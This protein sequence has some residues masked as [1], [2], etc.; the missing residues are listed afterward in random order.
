MLVSSLTPD[1]VQ[2]PESPVPM[3]GSKTNTIQDACLL[4]EQETS[5]QVNSTFELDEQV[6]T[7]AN[8]TA[9]P[10]APNPVTESVPPPA[11]RKPSV[12][13]KS[14][15]GSLAEGAGPI[16]IT[17]I[18]AE[19]VSST[20]QSQSVNITEQSFLSQQNLVEVSKLKSSSEV[21]VETQSQFVSTLTSDSE[22]PYSPFPTSTVPP[23]SEI[24]SKSEQK[25]FAQS[26]TVSSQSVSGFVPV[27]RE[28][29]YSASQFQ[30]QTRQI[31]SQ[32]S[33]VVS[34]SVLPLQTFADTR[35]TSQTFPSSAQ[36]HE[37]AKTSPVLS[38]L[39]TIPTPALKSATEAVVPIEVHSAPVSIPSD[40]KPVAPAL[41]PVIAQA[42]LNHE[43]ACPSPLLS[44]LTVAP[45]HPYSPLPSV[46]KAMVYVPLQS[47]PVST[48]TVKPVSPAAF[49]FG[50]QA[51]LARG[52][53]Y[54]SVIKP[55]S[56][57]TSTQAA[58]NR[59][60]ACPSPLIS[61]LTIAPERPYSPLPTAACPSGILPV[62][63][64]SIPAAEQPLRDETQQPLLSAPPY[65]ISGTTRPE[66]V[67]TKITPK[68]PVSSGPL[69][70]IGA[71]RPIIPTTEFKP[72]TS[73]LVSGKELPFHPVSD[74]LRAEFAVS[75]ASRPK[76]PIQR[77]S[78]PTSR[79]Q[80]GTPLQ[81]QKYTT[82][83]L[84]KPTIIPVYQ[85]Q[86]GEFPGQR[87]RSA[88]PT[89]P[90]TVPRTQTPQLKLASTEVSYTPQKPSASFQRQPPPQKP[91]A[92][93]QPAVPAASVLPQS[94]TQQPII[95]FPNIPLAEY[96]KTESLGTSLRPTTFSS[97]Q[98][99]PSAQQ[100]QL[101][102]SSLSAP[103]LEPPGPIF[104][105]SPL[106]APQSTALVKSSPLAPPWS[107]PSVSAPEPIIPKA[108]PVSAT[109]PISVAK[110]PSAPSSSSVPNAGGGGIGALGGTQ[111]GASFAGSSAPRRGRGVLTQQSSVGVRIALC[112]RCS[113]QIRGPFITALGK[114]WCPDHFVCVNAQCHRPLAD[115][116]FVE[117]KGEL[118]CEYCFEKYLAPS[119][120]KC[121][122]K[123]KGDCLNAIGKH[124]HPECFL[125]AYCGKLFGN[126][127]FFLEDGLPYC[128]TDWNELFTTKCFACGFPIEAGD[129]W[130]EALSN[131]YHSQ[132]F[133]C[134]N[135]KKNLEGQSF[136][137]KGGRPF[138]K[139][140]AR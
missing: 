81:Q 104:K 72:I 26:Q 80:S 25:V 122:T 127:P 10:K 125:C 56:L 7:V 82:T 131:N 27:S 54:P 59:E 36:D 83:G 110:T 113:S 90:M 75:P 71:F 135:C 95:P 51:P 88:T 14:R 66:P 92:S 134:T 137:A 98:P 37:T 111:K 32:Q 67:S 124:F 3:E 49:P 60:A 13:S 15:S 19:Q 112:A 133:N 129:R 89:C 64:P 58:L 23:K 35:P 78:T 24:I 85:Q 41:Q 53:A 20:S 116:G 9:V 30:Q 79:S 109:Q 136:Y 115:I 119:C 107:E 28:Q 48:Q 21:T 96:Y 123:V 33:S 62:Q 70:V 18:E 130:V 117:E 45:D 4:T 118:Y 84:Q 74:D 52:A 5:K 12:P 63:T 91:Y 73:E 43:A 34:E 16:R 100:Q 6:K 38:A 68:R 114:N 102:P 87:P 44:A 94:Q 61:A 132:C 17:S 50:V 1:A 69:P 97:A 140:H 40:T 126:N 128:E 139:A 138:C 86:M 77:V 8:E 99:F 55:A 106:A 22:R 103:Q 39:S 76:T 31:S 121:S 42:L 57:P 29:E 2:R 108:V 120:D 101:G 105:T 46:T 47:V 93:Y 11:E 65:K